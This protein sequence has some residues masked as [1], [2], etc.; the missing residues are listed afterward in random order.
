VDRFRS[1]R[2]EE[3][4]LVDATDADMEPTDADPEATEAA[5]DLLELRF[6]RLLAVDR[7]RC[8]RF[9]EDDLVN[10]DME[11][12]DADP[13]ATEAASEDLHRRMRPLFEDARELSEA[14]EASSSTARGSFGGADL[15]IL[16]CSSVC[17][18]IE[19]LDAGVLGRPR[20]L[21][22]LET[23]RFV[24]E[25]ASSG[26]R[27]GGKLSC[28]CDEA[29]S[30]N[31]RWVSFLLDL[32][33]DADRLADPDLLF[34]GGNLDGSSLEGETSVYDCDRLGMDRDGS[35]TGLSVIL[36]NASWFWRFLFSSI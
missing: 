3:D 2:F 30:F 36:A 24:R 32:V 14:L 18:G 22:D 11:P 6:R 25:G 35:S 23:K 26:I 33:D 27:S 29:D 16:C 12:T 31:C 15:S 1:D 8:D 17:P 5:S 21:R 10:A 19:D 7:F 28:I 13:E 34:L 4:D 20:V 9:E